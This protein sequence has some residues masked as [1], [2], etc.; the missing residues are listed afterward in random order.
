[1]PNWN[2][3][4]TIF[5]PSYNSITKTTTWKKFI[6]KNCF[7]GET[8]A[9]SFVS[10]DIYKANT[11]IVRIPPQNLL[12][13]GIGSYIFVGE[14]KEDIAENSSGKELFK[15]YDG[16]IVNSYRDNTHFPLPHHHATGARP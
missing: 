5:T 9:S 8:K 6:A 14:V 7:Y 3:V 13:I 10:P 4:L 1:M 12:S 11:K 15:S 2:Y 16:F